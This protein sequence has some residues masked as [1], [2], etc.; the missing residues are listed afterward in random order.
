[1]SSADTPT[2]R[3]SRIKRFVKAALSLAALMC[4]LLIAASYYL[5]GT[6]SGLH[7]LI[8]LSQAWLP[9]ELQIEQ[10]DGPLFGVLT[11]GKILYT[12]PEL[13]LAVDNLQ[14]DWQPAALLSGRLHITRLLVDRPIITLTNNTAS[15]PETPTEPLELTDII[16]PLQLQLDQIQV[17]QLTL[18][19]PS[20]AGEEIAT[21]TEISALQLSLHTD[22]QTLIL[23]RLS[24]A[25]PQATLALSGQLTPSGQFPLKLDTQWSVTLAEQQPLSGEGS[26]EGTLKGEQNSLTVQ[27][28]LSGLINTALSASVQN[29][30]EK[31]SGQLKL[32]DVKTELEQFTPLLAG[33]NLQGSAKASGDADQLQ[34]DSLWQ[35]NL[36]DIGSTQLTLKLHLAGRQLK[37]DQLKLTQLSSSPGQKPIKPLTLALQGTLDLASTPLSFAIQGQWH[38][39]RYPFNG[40]ASYLS[41][42][43]QLQ[44]NGD[45]QHYDLKLSAAVAGANIPAGQ[46]TLT[47]SGNQQA[48]DTFSLTGKTLEGSIQLTGGVSWQPS[49]S[50]TL[51]LAGQQLNPASHWPEWP[52]K[53][54][55]KAAINGSLPTD[56]PLKLQVKLTSLNGVL[57]DEPIN[58]HATVNINGQSVAVPQ[59]RLN[60][61]NT[62]IESHGKLD[63]TLDLSWAIR[64][65]DLS[66]L[67]P[68]LQGVLN[69]SGSLTGS[70]SA[71]HLIAKIDGQN[72]QFNQYRSDTL[73]ADLDVNLSANKQSHIELNASQLSLAGQRWQQLALTGQGSAAQHQLTL[74]TSQ[75][76]VDI[77]VNLNGRWENSQWRGLIRQLD[78][79]QADLGTWQIQRPAPLQLSS[80]AAVLTDLCLRPL[81][82]NGSL[83]LGGDWSTKG[84]LAGSLKTQ[85]LSLKHVQRW[86]PSQAV[87]AGELEADIR[88]SQAPEKT[89]LVTGFARINGAE[90]Q[91]EEEDL[92]VIA[93][94][95]TL[96]LNGQNN[97]LDA[98]LSIPLQQPTGQLTARIKVA[99]INAS[100]RLNA[101]LD[102]ALSDL[103]F[104][105][106]FTPQLQAITGQVNADMTLTGSVDNPL[107]EGHLTLSD[108][109]TDL[110][111]LG[112]KLEKIN[113]AVTGEPG[114]NNLQLKGSLESG[115][116]PIKIDGQYNPVTDTG[117][118]ALLGDHFKAIATEE[119][120]AWI[121][122]AI[123]LNITPKLIT[124]RGELTIPEANI[125]PPSIDASSPLSDD[126]VILDPADSESNPL[127]QGNPKRLL[128]AQ[129]RI[130]LGD[131]VYLEALGFEG[132]LLGSILVEDN[133]RQVTRATGIMQ[134]ASGQYRLYGQ[135]L[136]IDR[137][138]LI[139]SGGP[140]DNP[141]LDLRVSRTIDEVTAGAKV[142]GTLSDPRLSLFSDPVMP[143]SSQLSYLMFGHAPGAG[144][145]SLSEQEL[146]FKAASALTLKGGNTIA[147]QISETF[148]IDD[149]GVAGGDTS[150][151]TSL[152]IG[153]YLSPRLYVKYGV[154]LLEP[155]HTFFMRY[156][157]NQSWSVETQTAS[158]H[159][160]GDIFYTL[161]R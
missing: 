134:V 66:Q 155:T 124:L 79:T 103:K 74:T 108:A 55:L 139:Y 20:Q 121:S 94:D 27:Q 57:R 83:C 26:I 111:A 96:D 62:E 61:A 45:L 100:Q 23:R 6:S 51:N 81:N 114:N 52:G 117:D 72:L 38:N 129:L 12:Q 150:T 156:K 60:V 39:L 80:D 64:S 15:E 152:Y 112:I 33:S 36:P 146:L 99:D 76:P 154:G 105:S 109:S 159:N 49:V 78:L 132:R 120:Q 130:T 67:M 46:W 90:L 28:R 135:D 85:Q 3:T 14:L 153:K 8:N 47:G 113:L 91:L 126:V 41:P 149:L 137:G 50:W 48:L 143:E 73:S 65:P 160:G 5:L 16:L 59:L 140:I 92:Q 123:T 82:Y 118:I 13:T 37:V 17:R 142:S 89:P 144:G 151:D 93:G 119:I 128:D 116:G 97:Q 42:A 141:G 161:E 44:L 7:R 101:E 43:G 11:L 148:N 102:L 10:I 32:N 98:A 157:L 138:S 106:L 115:K 34:L 29:L 21:A 75:G 158:E 87:L 69:G 19:Q 147:E 56:Q 88:F 54:N 70:Q 24:I 131:K 110:P 86:I 31:P 4:L 2:P 104:I 35:T 136:D 9:G 58:G 95:I 18:N 133:G 107:V 68:E 30:L 25:A 53:L 63:G 1:M 40:T 127:A 122:P 22:G 71:P 145:N 125:Q 77:D 84:G